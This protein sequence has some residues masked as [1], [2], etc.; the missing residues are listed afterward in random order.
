MKTARF[1]SKRKIW[2]DAFLCDNHGELHT[3]K[4]AK[5]N[6]MLIIQTAAL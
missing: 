6:V 4:F 5:D 3:V 1:L 2:N